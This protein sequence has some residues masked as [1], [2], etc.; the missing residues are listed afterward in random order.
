MTKLILTAVVLGSLFVTGCDDENARNYAKELVGVLKSYQTEVNTKITAEKKSY[1][2]LA[3]AHAYARQVEL[4]TRLRTERFTRADS[5]T[6]DLIGGRTL[7][8]SDI[9]KL[10]LDHANLEFEATRQSLVQESDG[11]AEYIASLES[12]ELQAQNIAQL[13]QALEALA[14]PKSDVKKLRELAAAAK[15]LK[16]KF[17]ELECA[18]L[19]EQIACLKAQ[20]A[21]IDAATNLTPDQKKARKQ[22]LE[23]QIKSLLELGKEQKCDST[24]LTT[25]KCPDKKG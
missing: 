16:V 7:S 19:A 9:H 10:L 21:A 15:E 20:Q 4:L 5:L 13:T 18:D 17:D 14:K 24:K 1:K 12:L 11:Q 25:A 3:G 22:K 8:P 6:D 23:N 2:D